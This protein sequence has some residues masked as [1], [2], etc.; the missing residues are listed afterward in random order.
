MQYKKRND[1]FLKPITIN[2]LL[3]EGKDL[4][5][6]TYAYDSL[7]SKPLSTYLNDLHV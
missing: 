7:K 1:V 6:K 4:T 5:F 3:G 2:H